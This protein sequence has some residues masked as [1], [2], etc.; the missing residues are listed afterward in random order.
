MCSRSATTAAA[1]CWSAPRSSRQ[2]DDRR[3]SKPD[4]L[5]AILYTSGTTGPQQG[6]DADARQSVVERASAEGVLALAA[7][8]DVLIH[9]LPLFHVHGLFVAIARRAAQRQQDDLVRQV[10]SAGG[11]RAPA[12]ATVFMGVPTLYVRLLAEPA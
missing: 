1:R 11:D 5:A 12:E 9:A 6:R 7:T 4:D 8:G 10:R 3:A 2:F